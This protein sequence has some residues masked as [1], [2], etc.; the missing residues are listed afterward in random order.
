MFEGL[1]VACLLILLVWVFWWLC[2]YVVYCGCLVLGYGCFVLTS[3]L[4]FW[5]DYGVEWRFILVLF[6]TLVAVFWLWLWCLFGLSYL[7]GAAVLCLRWIAWFVFRCVVI[8]SCYCYKVWWMFVS[9]LFLVLFLF[10]GL[11]DCLFCA[12]SCCYLLIFVGLLWFGFVLGLL[13]RFECCAF[14]GFMFDNYVC[15]GFGF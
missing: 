9:Y 7:M 10:A 1:I 3:G 5:F 13:I 6:G 12:Y 11:L 8:C 15:L 2:F 4:V 14:A